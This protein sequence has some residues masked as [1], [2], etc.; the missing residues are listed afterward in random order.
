MFKSFTHF[1]F[2]LVYGV[3]WRSSFIFFA[4]SCPVLPAPLIEETV[5]SFWDSFVLC[6]NFRKVLSS[7]QYWVTVT[8]ISHSLLVPNHAKPPSS[9]TRATWGGLKKKKNPEFMYNK[10]CIYSYMFQLQTP[11]NYFPFYAIHL[12][13]SFFPMAQNSFWT[14]WF[15]CLL[16]LLLF[17][18]SPLPH[19]QSVSLWGLFSSRETKKNVVQGEISE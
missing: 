18:V 17:F 15:W 8:E 10:L 7:Y 1:Q 4:G 13:R 6:Q 11:S 14:H 12:S 2:T 5:Y 19:W 16:V 9:S 3:G